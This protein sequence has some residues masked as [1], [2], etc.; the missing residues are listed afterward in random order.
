MNNHP[1]KVINNDGEIEKA[2][3][4]VLDEQ[5]R[6]LLVTDENRS[7]WGLPKG[8]AEA[9]ESAIQVAR[10]ETLEETGYSVEIERYLGDMTYVNGTTKEK[11]R[12]H[13]YLAYP[14]ES[15]NEAEELWEWVDYD[16]ALAR[17]PLN[18]NAFLV[19]HVIKGDFK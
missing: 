9:G 16:Q 1:D 3:C 8:H 18:T 2:G 12:V 13:Y 7:S 11:I 14:R 19:D 10:R 17:V 15:G 4:V 5:G 6:I